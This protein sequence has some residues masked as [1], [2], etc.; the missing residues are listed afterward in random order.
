MLLLMKQRVYVSCKC[1]KTSVDAG[2]GYYHR[3]NVIEGVELPRFYYQKK[4][5]SLVMVSRKKKA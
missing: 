5:G 1:G 3:L 4:K 2:N